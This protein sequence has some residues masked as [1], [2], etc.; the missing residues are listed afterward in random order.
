[1]TEKEHLALIELAVAECPAGK[2]IIAGTGTNDTAPGRP[3]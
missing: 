2:S 1:M 3:A